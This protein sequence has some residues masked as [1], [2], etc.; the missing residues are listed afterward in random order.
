MVK[1]I[2]LTILV[3]ALILLIGFIWR[4]IMTVQPQLKKLM[5][6]S[7]ILAREEAPIK[8]QVDRLNRQLTEKQA[9]LERLHEQ[10]QSDD[11]MTD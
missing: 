10:L 2:S 11:N 8:E 3:L 1:I 6:M 9:I 4:F 7:D 5:A